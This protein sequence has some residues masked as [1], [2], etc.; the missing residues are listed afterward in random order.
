MSWSPYDRDAPTAHIKEALRLFKERGGKTIVELGTARMRINHPLE[1]S[2]HDCCKDGHA[3]LHFAQSGAH[4]YSCDVDPS[5]V[6]IA[7]EM[8]A[9]YPK[10]RV[11]LKDGHR[12]LKN[13]GVAIDLL[14]LDAWDVDHPQC[15]YA[16]LK[17]YRIAKKALNKSANPLVLIDDTDVAMVDGKLTPVDPGPEY[18]ST[19]KGEL[20]VPEMIKDDWKVLMTGRCT[21]LTRK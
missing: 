5:A 19:G 16:H 9:S 12:F 2:H 13:F 15:A 1:E 17:A 20:V 6:Q 3:L 4:V 11:L 21:L 14:S 10:T 7:K 8:V 18:R